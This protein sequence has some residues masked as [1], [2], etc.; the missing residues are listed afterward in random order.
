MSSEL[1]VWFE[2][3]YHGST[4]PP[5]CR[6]RA[7]VTIKTRLRWALPT[8]T[9]WAQTGHHSLREIS[10][11]QII[12]VPPTSGNPRVKLARAPRSILTTL[13]ARKMIFTDPT[14]RIRVGNIERRTPLPADTARL[15]EAFELRRSPQPAAMAALLIFR[16][17]RPVEPRDLKP[18]DIRDAL[19]PARPHR[20][21][22]RAGQAR[23]AAYLDDRHCRWPG[24]RNPHFFLHWLSASDTGPVSR[25]W[26]NG[27]LG[28]TAMA[29]RQD[30]IVD[31]ALATGG[32]MRR[33]CDL[34]GVT[35]TT[36]EHHASVLGH[37]RSPRRPTLLPLTSREPS[38]PI[39]LTRPPATDRGRV[40]GR[41]WRA[42][43]GPRAG[44]SPPPSPD[45]QADPMTISSGLAADHGATRRTS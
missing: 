5:R 43:P 20:P 37:P 25:H 33:I 14:A 40:R 35:I 3:L 13:K 19:L 16:G 30:R 34:C 32:D 23:L 38:Q 39:T 31:E 9:T 8:L 6:P 1:R 17:L 11:T 44:Q 36:A 10:R 2:V 29:A 45:Q 12:E 27:R 18:T 28:M 7:P 4:T 42:P 21:A 24:G 26:V 41:R 22:G 15:G